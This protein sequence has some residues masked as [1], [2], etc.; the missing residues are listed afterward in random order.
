MKEVI[1]ADRQEIKISFYKQLN[2]QDGNI[3]PANDPIMNLYIIINHQLNTI[4]IYIGIFTN[5]S[6]CKASVQICNNIIYKVRSSFAISKIQELLKDLIQSQ[7]S[8]LL[9]RFAGA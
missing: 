8:H 4:V 6:L 2:D 1:Q 7:E 9:F 5:Q 3:K